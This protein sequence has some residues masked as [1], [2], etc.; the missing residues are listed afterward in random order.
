MTDQYH[1]GRSSLTQ[2][3]EVLGY[4]DEAA[5][6]ATTLGNT[7]DGSSPS[8]GGYNHSLP[9]DETLQAGIGFVPADS[10]YAITK[11]GYTAYNQPSTQPESFNDGRTLVSLQTRQLCQEHFPTTKRDVNHQIGRFFQLEP[12]ARQYHDRSCSHI[13]GAR[14]WL[15]ARGQPRIV[16]SAVTASMVC[17]YG[18]TGFYTGRQ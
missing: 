5:P 6:V 15:P 18:I 2:D 4:D 8:A 3:H 7:N 10:T 12:K 17:T 9:I 16:L 14:D 13:W 11:P 1:P